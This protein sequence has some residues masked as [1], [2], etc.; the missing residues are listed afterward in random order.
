M[1]KIS[2]QKNEEEERKLKYQ[3]SDKAFII[4]NAK[5]V[6][7]YFRSNSGLINQTVDTTK[8]ESTNLKVPVR[9]KSKVTLTPL[10]S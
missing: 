3:Q 7:P 1:E 10:S 4:R 8:V 5:S 9:G 6:R 2:R